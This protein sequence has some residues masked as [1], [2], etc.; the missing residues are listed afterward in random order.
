MWMP[1]FY[2]LLPNKLENTYARLYNLITM[3][4]AAEGVSFKDSI[5]VMMDF[6]L[7]E[8]RP[9]QQ[10]HPSHQVRGCLFH[11][12]QSV[13]RHVQTHGGSTL[14]ENNSTIRGLVWM[15]FSLPLL[16]MDRLGEAVNLM[17]NEIRNAPDDINAWGL[18]FVQNYV[19][20]YWIRGPHRPA[21]WNLYEMEDN[22]TN[23]SAEGGNNRLFTRM[24]RSHPNINLFISHLKKE[25]DWACSKLRQA[26]HG[27]IEIPQSRRTKQ[28]IRT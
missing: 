17:V 11:Y 1:L 8:R 16:P 5:T 2:A 7:A 15:A 3:A 26:E 4:M 28:V 23:N 22:L 9:W 12:I 18:N 25:M 20:N 13:W 10:I 19:T 24:G 14:Y 21:D 6:E 27:L